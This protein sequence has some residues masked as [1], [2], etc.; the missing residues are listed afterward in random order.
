M[1]LRKLRIFVITHKDAF[2]PESPYLSLVQVGSAIGEKIKSQS[3][4]Y[5][6]TGDNISNYNR[7]FCEMTG[8]YWLWKNGPKAENIGIFHY[9][10]YLC[11]KEKGHSKFR[12]DWKRFY[13][14]P[15]LTQAFF[16]MELFDEK[17]I[18][19]LLDKYKIIIP[20]RSYL[21]ERNHKNYYGLFCFRE[22]WT[23]E[24]NYTLKIAAGMFPQYKESINSCSKS[25][26]GCH[27]NMFIMKYDLFDE[28]CS[29]IFPVLLKVYR[30]IKDGKLQ[31]EAPRLMG[32]LAEYLTGVFIHHKSR[33]VSVKSL[34]GTYFA[35]T[36]GKSHLLFSF[37]V[38]FK[39]LARQVVFPLSSRRRKFAYRIKDAIWDLRNRK[40]GIVNL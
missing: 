29:F 26:R 36:D 34:D 7:D 17:Y 4:L 19:S 38:D 37:W 18:N 10:R 35:R 9:R 2:I 39:L 5:D 15:N 8:I 14:Y 3:C 23:K 30:D 11:C 32:Y 21:G 6:D 40:R 27:C 31:T 16:D 28:Y 25:V 24:L 22:R 12:T 33:N 20:K 13:V 1:N